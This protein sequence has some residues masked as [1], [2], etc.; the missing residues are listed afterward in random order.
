MWL[1]ILKKYS[2]NDFLTNSQQDSYSISTEGVEI[3]NIK[4]KHFP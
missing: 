3:S 1:N 4:K 2:M